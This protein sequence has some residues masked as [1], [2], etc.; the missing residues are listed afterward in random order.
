MSFMISKTNKHHTFQPSCFASIPYHLR[1][2]L[3]REV[4]GPPLDGVQ[5]PNS[6]EPI[7]THLKKIES[8]SWTVACIFWFFKS[9]AL[10]FLLVW[11]QFDFSLPKLCHGSL[12]SIWHLFFESW[13]PHSK[14]HGSIIYGSYSVGLLYFI[15]TLT[16]D[17]HLK[18]PLLY[19]QTV[20]QCA[21]HTEIS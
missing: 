11:N 3:G 2:C 10:F 1:I 21:W 8:L 4:L 18:W 5:G 13:T 19:L 16:F 20:K 12:T 15:G 7:W 6:Q 17:L 9:W 14:G